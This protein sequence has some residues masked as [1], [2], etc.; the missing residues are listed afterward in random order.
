[1][2]T[3]KLKIMNKFE[4][5]N[6]LRL[7]NDI[8]RFSYNRFREG[9]KEVEVRARCRGVFKGSNSWFVQCAI[10]EGKAVFE[11][12]KEKKVIF[13]G[14]A[15]LKQYMKKLISKAE[16]QQRRLSPIVIQGEK[17]CGGNRL[18]NF[19]LDEEKLELKL[20]RTDHRE[21]KLPRLRGNL[22]KE[23]ANLQQLIDQKKATVTVKFNEEYVW[24]TYDENL[25][26]IQKFND[27][28]K[29]RVLGI[30]L[31]P[32]YIGLSVLEFDSEDK[33]KV[34]H[35]Q[36]FDLTALNVTSKKSSADKA[37]KYLTNKRKFEL[38]EICHEISRM[39][40]YWKCSKLCI[41]DLSIKSS[42]KKQG[43]HF[44]RL[45]NNVWNRNLVVNKLKL[46]SVVHGFELVEV[47]PAYSSF[48]GNMVYG[49]ENT[50]DMVASSIE[51][52][53]RGYKKYA[54]GW[55]YPAFNADSI[56]EQLK[57]TLAEIGNWIEAFK[58]IK[59]LGLKYRFQLLDYVQNAVFSKFYSKKH[60]N[61]Y[62]FK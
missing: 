55:F 29:N 39:M 60:W 57:Q 1:M 50:P 43:R 46:L 20:S 58:K 27:L 47:N 54:K 23:F 33:F 52:A 8:L 45:C 17:L 31:N 49:D 44:N 10:K 18:F 25:L 3:I 41:E 38:I 30:D 37:S 13:G 15:S 40:D 59:E 22:K 48:V 9:L 6:E 35:K 51:I 62:A 26:D 56:D 53:R 14:K 19:K 11:K 42:D 36:V 21:I 16:Y 24:L 61:L 7:F 5:Q 32:N 34:L 28:K 4:C 2:K 12:F